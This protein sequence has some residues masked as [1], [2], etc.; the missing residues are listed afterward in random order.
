MRLFRS[1]A[2]ATLFLALSLGTARAGL[3]SQG[4]EGGVFWPTSIW[5]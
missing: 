5:Y 4:F 2:L 3:T 1:A